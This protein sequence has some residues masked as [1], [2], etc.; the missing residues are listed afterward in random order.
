MSSDLHELAAPYAL[1]AL[2]ADE[3]ERF[4]RHLA[5]CERCS[6][7]L[8]ELQEAVAAL[9][10]AVEGPE[11]PPAL[12]GRILESAREESSAKVVAFPRRRWALPAVA[13]IAAVAACAAIGLGIWA[14]SLSN[15]LD[16]ER[17][18]NAMY[19]QAIELLGA[20]AQV[21]AL[22]DGEGRLLVAPGGGR[23]ALVVCGLSSSSCGQDVPGLG[24]RRKDT[25]SGRALS[26]RWRLLATGPPRARRPDRGDRR[27][28]PRARRRC[29]GTN[30]SDPRP[31]GG[32]LTCPRRSGTRSLPLVRP[33]R[34]TRSRPNV[35]RDAAQLSDEALLAAVAELRR[36]SPGRA[37]RPLRTGRLR[38]GAAHP[39]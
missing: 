8:A 21:K 31:L 15:S 17:S 9:A 35:R 7:Q 3:R 6:A 5:E 33:R 28:H 30:D 22:A 10:F 34:F 36:G 14:S 4:E 39:S 1:D 13:T 32:G 2:D 37:L 25:A 16:R 26:R 29:A 23:A 11:P 18:A 12:R 27:G 38:P 20:D 19:A 24:D